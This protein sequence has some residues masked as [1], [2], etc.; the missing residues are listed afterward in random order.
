MLTIKNLSVSIEEKPILRDINLVI[1]PGEIH[2]VMGP[3]GSGK[4]TLAYALAGHPKYQINKQKTDN[5]KLEDLIVLDGEEISEMSPDERANLGLYLAT[6]YPM[7][8]PGLTTFNF[9]WQI[10]KSKF[11]K[12]E[13]RL[14]K[15]GNT[16]TTEN[17]KQIS[18]IEFKKWMETQVKSLGL[19]P[20]ILKRGLNDGLSGGEKKKTEVLQM[21]VSSPR[22]IILDEIDSGLDVDALKKIAQTVAKIAKENQ[23]G[24]LVITHYS[25]ILKYLTPDWVHIIKAGEMVETG[26]VE[27]VEKI[28]NYGFRQ[29]AEIDVVEVD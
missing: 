8:V 24:V 7:A 27:L 1:K 28:E 3:N 19:K 17:K 11:K 5:K 22:Y 6:Q 29:T 16:Q 25:R 14:Q 21:L 18:L 20:E 15:T 12:T 23:V 13:D 10:Y 26:G 9:L 4:S 2:A